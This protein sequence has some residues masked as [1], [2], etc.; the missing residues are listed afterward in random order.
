MPK[1]AMIPN[2]RAFVSLAWVIVNWLSNVQAQ[3]VVLVSL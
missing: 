3:E 2:F 1:K